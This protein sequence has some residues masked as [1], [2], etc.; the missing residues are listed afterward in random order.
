MALETAISLIVS[1]ALAMAAAASGAVFKPG[2]WYQQLAKPS[3]RPPDWAFGPVWMVL[4]ATMAVAAWLVYE[5]AG[6]AGAGTALGIYLV[7]LLVNAGWSAV[8]FG[9]RSPGWGLIEV[10]GLW[11]SVLATIVAFLPIHMTAGL[12]LLPY[13]AWVSVATM[14]NYRIWQLNPQGKPPVPLP[15]S[16][17]SA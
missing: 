15:G 4:Y 6:F 10:I 9:L 13:L 3:W 12:L 17:K 1:V 7:H 14:L 2:R 16:T 5:K 11:T 8:F